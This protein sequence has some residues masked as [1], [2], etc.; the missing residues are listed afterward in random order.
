MPQNTSSR[1]WFVTGCSSGMGRAI[2]EAIAATNDRLVV[3]ARKIEQIQDIQARAS[4]RILALAVDIVDPAS[5][6]RA[7]SAAI[8]KFG[9]IDVLVNNA[10]IGLVGAVEEC[11]QEEIVNTFRT[12]VFGT[13][14]VIQEVLPHMRKRRSG[15]ILGMT[16][17]LGFQAVPAVGIYSATKCALEGML[18]AMAGEVAPLGIKVT[19]LQP[20]V[21]KTDF[22]GKSLAQSKSTIADY[23][24]TS[25]KMRAG[26]VGYPASAGDPAKAAAAILTMVNSGKTP[27]IRLAL[28][29]DAVSLI[30]NKLGVIAKNVAEWES[31]SMVSGGSEGTMALHS[32]AVSKANQ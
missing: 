4:D 31:L 27:P 32:S 2:A 16:S 14:S 1:V 24:D 20:G 18:E 21:Y 29:A 28:G 15:L 7:V 25:G 3:T 13:I 17:V 8:A 26:L 6:K 5:V 9:Q 12:N 19:I 10:G 11:T 30:K 23:A 22:R